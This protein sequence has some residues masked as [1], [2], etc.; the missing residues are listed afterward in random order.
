MDVV[1][2]ADIKKDAT[3]GTSAIPIIKFIDGPC[4]VMEFAE[5]GG[6]LVLDREAS[7]LGIFDKCDI[8]RSFKCG[9]CGDVI[10]PP[11]LSMIEQMEYVARCVSRKGGYNNLLK[12][13]VIQASLM[14][15]KFID[16]FL[17]AKQ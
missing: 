16:H 12:Q 13:M 3:T 15:G 8:Y 2:Y 6:V 9:V 1:G 17:W 7:G 14:E 11:G 10:T 4:R 5:D